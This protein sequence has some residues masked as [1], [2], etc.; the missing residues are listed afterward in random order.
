MVL[1]FYYN[2]AAESF[3]RKK[4]RSTVYLIEL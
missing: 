3:H 2:F 1:Y 4:L